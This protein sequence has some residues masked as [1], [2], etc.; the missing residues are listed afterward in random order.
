MMELYLSLELSFKM[1]IPMWETVINFK[2][3]KITEQNSVYIC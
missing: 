3:E 1:Y 2:H